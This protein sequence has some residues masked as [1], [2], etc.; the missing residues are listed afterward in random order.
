MRYFKVWAS[1]FKGSSGEKI[2]PLGQNHE[3]LPSFPKPVMT[4]LRS[5]IRKVQRTSPSTR[6]ISIYDNL[7]TTADD[8]HMQLRE[9]IRHE[10]SKAT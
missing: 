1:E 5:F 7:S 4:G 8:Y 2:A 3:R 10:L 9:Y 6:G